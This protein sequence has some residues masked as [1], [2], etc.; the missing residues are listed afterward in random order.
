LPGLQSAIRL[1]EEVGEGLGTGPI[2]L[3]GVQ[4]NEATG[5]NIL[6]RYAFITLLATVNA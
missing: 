1:A 5:E 3:R 6:R 4:E 2:L